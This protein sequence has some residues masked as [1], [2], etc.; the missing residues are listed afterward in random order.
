MHPQMK[1]FRCAL[2]ASWLAVSAA[3]AQQPAVPA[4]ARAAAQA[5]LAPLPAPTPPDPDPQP[6]PQQRAA[7]QKQDAEM[8]DAAQQVLELVDAGR[9]GEVWDGASAVMKRAVPREEFVY[10]VSDERGRLG[11]PVDRGTAGVTR[12]QFPAGARVP[13]GIYVNVATP[14]RFQKSPG[15]VRELVSFRLDEDRVW[16]VSGYS[17]R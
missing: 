16:R 1:A 12:T 2:L 4:P 5:P 10:Q 7:L 6:T 11:R 14:T 9:I 8:T 17:V 15:Q 13:Q 3:A